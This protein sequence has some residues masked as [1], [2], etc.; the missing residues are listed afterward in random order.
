MMLQVQTV[1]STLQSGSRRSALREE[2]MLLLLLLAT[3][4]ILWIRGKKNL[5]LLFLIMHV[6][7]L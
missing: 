2:V 5:Y 7:S 4:P 6:F 3:K 1:L